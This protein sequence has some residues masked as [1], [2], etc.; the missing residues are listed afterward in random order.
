[1]KLVLV[2]WVDSHSGRG[3]QPL[4]QIQDTSVPLRC[5]SV[6][7]LVAER[8]DCKVIVPHVSGEQN[9]G[10]VKSGCGDITIPNKSIV[11]LTVLRN[12]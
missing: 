6:G 1:M 3:W 4:D 11:K 7:W 2:E 9:E 8:N 10:I 5:R 12:S